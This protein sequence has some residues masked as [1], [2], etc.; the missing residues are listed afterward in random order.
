MRM[1]RVA[2]IARG[3]RLRA[4]TWPRLAEL[5]YVQIDRLEDLRGERDEPRRRTSIGCTARSGPR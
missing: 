4:V 2:V 3:A 1:T 5:G